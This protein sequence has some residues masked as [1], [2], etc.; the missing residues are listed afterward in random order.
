MDRS[1]CQIKLQAATKRGETVRVTGKGTGPTRFLA[2]QTTDDV[3]D[4]RRMATVEGEEKSTDSISA[5]NDER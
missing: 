5:L 2:S 4:E 3:V 1:L